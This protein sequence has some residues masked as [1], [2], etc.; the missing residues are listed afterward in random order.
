[1]GLS[2]TL[3]AEH[4]RYQIG[5]SKGCHVIKPVHLYLYDI[6]FDYIS[7]AVSN[8]KQGEKNENKTILL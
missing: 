2:D 7:D 8:V 6:L 5:I 1:M 3:A 4:L